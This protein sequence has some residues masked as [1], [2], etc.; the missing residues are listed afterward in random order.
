MSGFMSAS[1]CEFADLSGSVSSTIERLKQL[2]NSQPQHWE[3]AFNRVPHCIQIDAK[4]VVH[5]YIAHGYDLFPSRDR[6][7]RMELSPESSSGLADDLQ[8]VHSPTL[9]QLII[10]ESI[11]TKFRVSFDLFDGFEDVTQAFRRVSHK[12]TASRR[13]LSRIR[14][15]RPRSLTTSTASPSSALSASN[16]AA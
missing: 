12:A 2:V 11:A 15:F 7:L 5:Q 10:I 16:N 3:I 9:Y 6:I 8:F 4:V 1:Q 13:T 14:G